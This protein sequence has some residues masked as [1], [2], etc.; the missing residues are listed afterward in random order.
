MGREKEKAKWESII[1]PSWNHTSR[2]KIYKLSLIVGINLKSLSITYNGV[3]VPSKYLKLL[4]EAFRHVLMKRQSQRTN[5]KKI[6]FIYSSLLSPFYG[7]LFNSPPSVF[8]H[9]PMCPE[10][11]KLSSMPCISL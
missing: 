10:F 5:E 6:N 9:H 7:I 8:H 3:C 4:I 11:I 1:N 2:R